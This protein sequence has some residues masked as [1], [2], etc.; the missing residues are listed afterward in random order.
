MS[1]HEP[2]KLKGIPGSPYTRKM[3]AC[4]RFPHIPYE[5]LIGDQSAALGLP[6]AGVSLLPTFYLPNASDEVEQPAFP[7]QA[8]CLQWI[9]AEYQQLDIVSKAYVD[10]I[11]ADTGHD[12]ILF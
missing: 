10:T 3:L 1:Q 12:T 11:V 2:L 4:M 7:Y 9:N 5:L 8:K 6:E